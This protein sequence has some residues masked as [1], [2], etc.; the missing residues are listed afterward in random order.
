MMLDLCAATGP[1]LD[2]LA[3]GVIE[4]Y[5]EFSLQHELGLFLRAQIGDAFRVQFERPTQFFGIGHRLTKREIDISV[6]QPDRREWH[7]IELK[8][9]R[10]GQYPEQ[11]FQFCKDVAFLEELACH[12]GMASGMLLIVADDPLFYGRGSTD[13]IYGPFR[14]GI[15]LTGEIRKPTGKRDVVLKIDGSYR[16]EWVSLSGSTKCARIVIPSQ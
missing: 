5:N 13:G 2:C 14:G 1:F 7:A 15:P 3:S 4:I 11:M 10:N 16:I 6:F 8:Y 12:G 9:P